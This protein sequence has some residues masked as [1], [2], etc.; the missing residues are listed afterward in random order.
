MENIGVTKSNLTSCGQAISKLTN[1]T[2]TNILESVKMFST[3]LVSTCI[4][5]IPLF[6]CICC[7]LDI[8]VSH[9]CCDAEFPNSQG[10]QKHPCLDSLEAFSAKEGFQSNPLAIPAWEP[11]LFLSGPAPEEFTL[12]GNPFSANA[13]PLRRHLLLSILVI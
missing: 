9:P 7:E 6:E 3:F 11:F 13:P 5:F 12:K 8:E 2:S 10:D 4:L 1:R